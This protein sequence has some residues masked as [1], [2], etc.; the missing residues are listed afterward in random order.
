MI[1]RI[2]RICAVL[3]A[4]TLLLVVVS[5]R[6]DSSN[7][8]TVPVTVAI[9]EATLSPTPVPSSTSTQTPTPE[10][11]PVPQTVS[12]K[13]SL[14]FEE[15]QRPRGLEGPFLYLFGVKGASLAKE[16]DA[17]IEVSP[18][19][20]GT[21]NRE[22][23]LVLVY[24]GS[25]VASG[26]INIRLCLS[27]R[28]C[29]EIDFEH[30]GVLLPTTT[31][32]AT[33]EPTPQPTPEATLT[34]EPTRVATPA[35]TPTPQPRVTPI[36]TT[37]LQPDR[38]EI[39]IRYECGGAVFIIDDYRLPSHVTDSWDESL[40]WIRYSIPLGATVRFGYVALETSVGR[41]PPGTVQQ[42]VPDA[43]LGQSSTLITN[44]VAGGSF[45]SSPRDGGAG[46]GVVDGNEHSVI[47]KITVYPEALYNRGAPH[48]SAVP[49]WL[50]SNV[51]ETPFRLVEPPIFIVWFTLDGVG[52]S[53]DTYADDGCVSKPIAAK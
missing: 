10:T 46:R 23:N 5:H 29:A 13:P 32:T 18:I 6:R 26:D 50:Y 42:F 30:E 9:P 21:I 28:P 43:T 40:V 8:E 39:P 17:V 11:S 53:L 1:Q 7:R 27:D 52:Y 45:V 47:L 15:M 48:H 38:G 44:F 34:P 22:G 20:E 14:V 3:I 24:V 25:G 33:T 19:G 12:V 36:P 41:I 31:A 16:T 49:G 2:F 51:A 37:R 35:P 4:V